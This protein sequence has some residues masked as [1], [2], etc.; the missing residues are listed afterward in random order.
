MDKAIIFGMFD[1]VGFHVG[2]HLL[3]KGIEVKGIHIE[4]PDNIH[5]I[6]E[7]RLE[8]GR[9]ANFLE[10][11]L[12]EWSKNE[13]HEIS[14]SRLIFSIY[15]LFMLK[16]EQI[17][18]MEE[19]TRPIIQ[20]VEENKNKAKIV[21][22]LP[23]QMLTRTY[24]GKEIERFLGNVKGLVT[25]I[26]LL[27]L[28]AIYGPWQPSAFLFQQAIA[29]KYKN[30]NLITDVREWTNDCLFVD[31]AIESMLEIIESGRPGSYLIESGNEDHW[32]R[33]AEYLN[34]D[35]NQALLKSN[36]SIEDNDRLEKVAVKKVSPIAD[37]IMTQIEHVQRLYANRL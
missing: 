36:V 37:S 16:K 26:Q 18:Q 8:V 7:K 10:Q 12:I 1:F 35:E 33:C 29:S 14:R 25:N 3:N 4:N 31:D 21:F 32:D 20:F 17:L 2:K 23:I 15:D 9:N 13:Q 5:F 19:V 27:Y 28:P 11:S 34:I 24:R 30:V 6:D 22:I